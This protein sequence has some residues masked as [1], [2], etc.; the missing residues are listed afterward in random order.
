MRDI[1]VDESEELPQILHPLVND[2]PPALA[3]RN[4]Q[5]RL[6]GEP[7]LLLLAAAVYRPF[8]TL[9]LRT[10]QSCGQ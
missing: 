8:V 9:S 1:S 7:Q 6:A 5:A 2:G 10:E 3:G 4:A